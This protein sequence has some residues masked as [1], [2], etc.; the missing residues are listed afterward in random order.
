MCE[1]IDRL[2]KEKQK[3]VKIKHLYD[4]IEHVLK[5]DDIK[6]LLN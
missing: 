4:K 2:I 1:N 5:Y 3:D 6:Q